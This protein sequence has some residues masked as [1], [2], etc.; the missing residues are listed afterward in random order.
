MAL[1][2][3]P[4]MDHNEINGFKTLFSGGQNFASVDLKVIYR[5][6]LQ[7]GASAMIL[8]HNHPSNCINPSA[9][10]HKITKEIFKAGKMLGIKLLDHLII[11]SGDDYYSFGDEGDIQRYKL[12]EY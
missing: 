1:G 11:A 10:D 2:L 6:A 12:E 9:E 4:E 5:Y 7:F 3:F 8:V